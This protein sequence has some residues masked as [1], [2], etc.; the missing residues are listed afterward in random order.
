MPAGLPYLYLTEDGNDNE[1]S[2]V[3]ARNEEGQYAAIAVADVTRVGDATSLAF[4]PSLKHMLFAMKGS[5]K[6]YM[7]EREDGE[8]FDAPVLATSYI[9]E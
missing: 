9:E 1:Q 4:S 3:F 8:S 5:G 2:G 6:V 7:V